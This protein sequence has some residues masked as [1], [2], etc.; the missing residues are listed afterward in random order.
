MEEVLSAEHKSDNL[1]QMS[2]DDS[3]FSLEYLFGFG[4]KDVID[5]KRRRYNL[6]QTLT[7]VIKDTI[8][9]AKDS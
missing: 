9:R 6:I 5:E 3:V 2:N 1:N 4:T 8:E 7:E